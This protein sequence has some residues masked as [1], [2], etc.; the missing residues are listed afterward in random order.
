MGPVV[1]LGASSDESR[2]SHM[3]MVNLREHGW[4]RIPVH[5]RETVVDGEKVL[6]NL[7]ALHGQSIHTVTM[8]VNPALS[9]KMAESL[10]ELKPQRVIFNPGSENPRLE[11][12]LRAQGIEVVEGCTLVMLR[13][14][15]F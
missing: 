14:K 13:T 9:D 8:Y 4:P 12:M 6:P 11:N 15:Q 5:P 2:Y 3:A 7:D 1:V 10:L